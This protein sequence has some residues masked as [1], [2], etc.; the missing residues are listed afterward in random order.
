MVGQSVDNLKSEVPGEI[1]MGFGG[2]F[3]SATRNGEQ[4][5][6]CYDPTDDGQWRLIAIG[7]KGECQ[8]AMAFASLDEGLVRMADWVDAERHGP[9]KLFRVWYPDGMMHRPGSLSAEDV[10]GKSGYSLVGNARAYLVAMVD[11]DEDP[12]QVRLDFAE[13]LGAFAPLLSSIDLVENMGDQ[14]CWCADIV[15]PA[16]GLYRPADLNQ[17]AKECLGST[18]L[19]LAAEVSIDE[20]E[21][22]PGEQ[23]KAVVLQFPA[24]RA[25]QG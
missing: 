9:R 6:L 25:A 11:V 14:D 12:A 7:P 5:E 10:L 3:L 13:R 24:M 2:C 15:L 16:N 17:F 19:E 21:Q 23:E 22:A 4:V 8:N 18:G 20:N 1:R